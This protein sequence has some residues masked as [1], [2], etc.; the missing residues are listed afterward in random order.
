MDQD[1]DFTV[2]EFVLLDVIVA[3]VFYAMFFFGLFNTTLSSETQRGNFN[4]MLLLPLGVALAYTYKALNKRAYI[5][6]NKKGIFL[7]RFF[8]TDWKNFVSAHI[9][10]KQV[11]G[12]YSDHFY[13]IVDHYAD[14]DYYSKEVPLTNTQNK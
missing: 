2:K 11:A 14:G 5:T 4:R 12:S 9:I 8:L 1:K 13:L 6:V 10:E 3:V 7:G